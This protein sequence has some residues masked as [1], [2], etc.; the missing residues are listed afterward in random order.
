MRSGKRQTHSRPP[1]PEVAERVRLG[2]DLHRHGRLDDAEQVY[3]AVLKTWPT[4]V[5]ALHYLGVLLFQ[6]GQAREGVDLIRRALAHAPDY[7]DAHN[8]LGNILKELG[9]FAEAEQAYRQVLRLNARHAEAWNNLGVAVKAGGRRQEAVDAFRKALELDPIRSDF[10]QNLGNALSGRAEEAAE[11]YRQWLARDPENPIA[12]HMLA[13]CSAAPPPQRASDAYVSRTFDGFAQHFDQV[14]QRLQYRAPAL[15]LAALEQALGGTGMAQDTVLDAGCGTGLCGPLLRPLARRLVGVDLSQGML[16]KARARGVYD[17]LAAAEL[18]A[19]LG[20]RSDAYDVIAC[21][22]TLCYF[23]DLDPVLSAAHA[24]LRPGGH[25]VF[26]V[27]HLREED[28]AGYRLNPFGRYAHRRGYVEQTVARAGLGLLGCSE[29]IL[30][31]EGGEPVA[32]LVV[33]TRRNAVG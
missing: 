4:Q 20:S 11:V 16:A 14:L 5:D 17:L 6:R 24:A 31:E 3:G 18:E 13:A 10:Y 1:G 32:G 22:D 30:R 8:N 28:S 15:V 33:S 9:R 19:Y 27:E 25:L 12:L 2:I 26:T 21:A 29:Q 7:A 23:G